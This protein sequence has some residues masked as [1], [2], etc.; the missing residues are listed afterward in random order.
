MNRKYCSLTTNTHASILT[1]EMALYTLKML[2]DEYGT[3]QQITDLVNSREIWM[4]F[5]MNPDGGEYDIST[6]SYLSW[7]KNR[8]PNAGSSYIGTDLNRNWG[9]RWGCCGGSS[10]TTSSETYRGS[11]AFLRARDGTSYAIL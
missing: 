3:T 1:V 10:G 7:R 2:T 9:Y 11:A 5:D 6:G 4:V 8:Q